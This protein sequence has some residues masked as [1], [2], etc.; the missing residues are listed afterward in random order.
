MILLDELFRSEALAHVYSDTEYL[1]SLLQFEAALARAEAD[2]GIIPEPAARAIAAKCHASLFDLKAISTGAAL[3][4]NLAIPIVKQLTELVAKDDQDAARFVH[5]GTTSQDAIDTAT[6]LQLRRGFALIEVDLRKLIEVLSEIAKAHRN[7]P[8]AARTLMQQALPTSFGFI[9]AGWLDALLR[10]QQRLKEVSDRALTLQFGGAVGTLA[11]LGEGGISVGEAL[12]K[13]LHLSLPATPWHSQ[14]DRFSEVA[15]TFG[16]LSGTLAKI[17][18]DISL[19]AQT[20][21]AE[22][23]EPSTSCRGGSSTLPH[24]RNPITCAVVLAAGI[25]VP[26]LVSTMLSTMVHEQQRSLGAWHAEWETLSE[27]VCLAGGALHHLAKMLSGLEVHSDHMLQNLDATKGL[28]FAE[29]VTFALAPHLGKLPA[30]EL[31]ASACKRA[32]AEK[33]H[34]KD[35]LQADP[36]FQKYLKTA[37]LNSLFEPQNY[38]GSAGVFID[39]VLD[40]ARQSSSTHHPTA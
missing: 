37:E 19:H 6:V 40:I 18:R 13:E 3:S 27:I 30:H 25:R 20:E 24:K 34:L 5:W 2:T 12:A 21:I 32:V 31:V 1:Q 22:L 35:I 33:R 17:A 26:P 16:L 10:D 39:R 14:R 15:T 38:M 4:A 36:N 11:S 23:S 29:A 28:I 7:T 9:V 8:I